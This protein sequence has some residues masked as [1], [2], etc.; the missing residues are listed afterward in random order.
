MS[1]EVFDTSHPESL[2]KG[3][4]AAR[5]A[6]AK[7]QLVVIPTDTHYAVAI[8]AFSPVAHEHLAQFKHW[9]T[10]PLPQV[11]LP[12]RAALGALADT[13]HPGVDVLTTAFW[14][15]PLTVVVPAS[16]TLRW[17]VGD[18]VSQVALRLVDHVVVEELLAETGPLAVSAAHPVGHPPDSI[19]QMIDQAGDQIAVVLTDPQC[20]W[21]FDHA[22]ST[23]VDASDM[24]DA[25]QFTV[26][27]EGVISRE[28]LEAATGGDV[29]WSG[30]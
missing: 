27:R 10:P 11:I 21:G 1:A 6:I 8:D 25:A 9:D 18:E 12:T 24:G 20:L 16:Q 28:Q 7:K 3:L 17:N 19:E 14:P 22:G 4:R 30:P 5:V 2:R 23:L 13:I 26:V 29:H 15:G